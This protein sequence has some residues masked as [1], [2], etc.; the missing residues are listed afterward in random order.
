MT[1][2]ALRPIKKK[3]RSKPGGF[4]FIGTGHDKRGSTCNIPASNALVMT[5]GQT[6]TGGGQNLYEQPTRR[7]P[8]SH[9]QIFAKFKRATPAGGERVNSS[10][11]ADI[12]RKPQQDQERG[13]P[14]PAQPKAKAAP[15]TATAAQ[16]KA[17]TT[18]A[19][20]Q[21]RQKKYSIAG[22]EKQFSFTG[23]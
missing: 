17:R 19:T 11:P 3:N 12:C 7:P 13:A 20:P 4:P 23:D 18:A 21:P 5:Q 22:E 16:P 14:S 10:P 8:P 9:A 15:P 1:A 6:P 2:A